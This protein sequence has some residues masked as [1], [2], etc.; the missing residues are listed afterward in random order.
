M[1]NG[2]ITRACLCTVLI[3]SAASLIG[4]KKKQPIALP[5]PPPAPQAV[6]L[7]EFNTEEYARIEETGFLETV[8]NPL[9]TFSVDVDTASYANVR[10]FLREGRLP[11]PD[12]VRIEEMINYFRYSYP[13][14]QGDHPFSIMTELASCPWQPN[15]Q[16]LSIGLK[17]RSVS[18]DDLPPNNLVFL[19]DVSGSMDSPDKLPLLR[20]AFALLVG[21]LRPQDRIAIVVYAGRAGLVLP[22]T[23]GSDKR[24][25]L[26][27]LS[28][29]EAGGSTAGG[30][31]IRLA[32]RVARENVI[33][34]GNNRVILATDGDF[35]VG[36]SSTSEL[37][38]LVEQERETGVFLSVLG[39]GTGNLKDTRME[40]LADK[41]NGNYSYID[42]ILEARKVLVHELGGTLAVVAKDVKIQLE[43]NPAKIRAYRLIG[44]ENRMLRAEDFKDDKKD[45]GDMGAGHTVTA[46]YEVIPA[47]NPVESAASEE[48]RYQQP[49]LKSA[50]SGREALT[51]KIRYKEP[52]ADS[53]SE[54][55]QVVEASSKPLQ[56][57]SEN[58]RFAT[59]VAGF[60]LLLRESQFKGSTTFDEVLNIA[61]KARGADAE[62]YRTEFEFLVKQAKRL[63]ERPPRVER[64]VSP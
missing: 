22:S 47:G 34:G 57:A 33:H 8:R 50:A 17:A 12:A 62:G 54:I 52:S 19:I 53:S 61:E 10:R 59:S 9:S 51:L 21:N 60:G 37:V 20:R 28:S 14:P 15:H 41:G 58:L 45:A 7:R 18:I 40:Q 11:P 30:E 26:D 56:S 38:R 27:A 36:V 13:E 32:Y 3:L 16:L 43:F 63:A 24:R 25:I 42:S 35:N 46:L 64:P 31:G 48:L 6:Y 29:L 23:P 49:V 4:C 55:A 1:L 39:V 5:P 2:I 44:Y